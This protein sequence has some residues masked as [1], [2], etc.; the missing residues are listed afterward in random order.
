MIHHVNTK[1]KKA[2]ET[3]LISNKVGLRTRKFFR[4]K[5]KY[6]IIK[7]GSVIQEDMHL[8]REH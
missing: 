7:K 4:N 3:I 8:T 2:E 6:Y 5:D 1:Q